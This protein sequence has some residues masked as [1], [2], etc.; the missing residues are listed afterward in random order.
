M[1]S[2]RRGLWPASFVVTKR[3]VSPFLVTGA[4]IEMG[5]RGQ[6]AGGRLP[7]TRKC[8]NHSQVVGAIGPTAK[9][10]SRRV[11]RC[12]GGRGRRRRRRACSR[13]ARRRRFRS[14]GVQWRLALMRPRRV[15]HVVLGNAELL[16]IELA[17]VE[18]QRPERPFVAEVQ[19]IADAGD[20]LVK[21]LVQVAEVDAAAPG[22][23]VR[24]ECR[25]GE[26]RS[27]RRITSPESVQLP[28]RSIASRPTCSLYCLLPLG[29][30]A[31]LHLDRCRRRRTSRRRCRRGPPAPSTSSRPGSVRRWSAAAVKHPDRRDPT[32]PA[33]PFRET[34]SPRSG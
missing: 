9:T 26:S 18:R 7:A 31:V 24:V 10:G 29:A 1:T 21:R 30:D 5:N 4:T 16:G 11:R 20:R 27:G 19:V 28:R 8:G 12:R 15:V 2:G 6:L 22:D 14:C 13:S 23:V 33:G 32:G 34:G 25:A 17:V 3:P